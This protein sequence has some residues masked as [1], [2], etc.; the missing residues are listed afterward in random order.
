MLL[1][2]G[3]NRCTVEISRN[4]VMLSFCFWFEGGGSCVLPL[5]CGGF[6]GLIFTICGSNLHFK[7]ATCL[8]KF[9]SI[10]QTQNGIS[11]VLCFFRFFV[12]APTWGNDPV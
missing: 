8:M 4:I 2:R 7:A 5:T 1:E 10:P 3:F 6:G 11:F 12:F 9:S